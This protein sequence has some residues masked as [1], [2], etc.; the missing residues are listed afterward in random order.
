MRSNIY[1]EA[2]TSIYVLALI[3]AVSVLFY[4]FASMFT[5]MGYEGYK[6]SQRTDAPL[7]NHKDKVII[8]D[9]GHGGEDPGAVCGDLKEKDLNLDVASILNEYFISS[10]YKTVMTRKEDAL[11]YKNGEENRKKYYDLKNRADIAETYDNGIFVSI[12]MNKFPV[13][14]CKGLQ[15][16]YSKNH[17]DGYAIA[18][19][20][21]SN[22]K[23]LQ[24]DNN[25][26]VKSGNDT[27]YLMNKLQMP[28][29]LIEC[30][31]LS[32]E[33]EYNLLKTDDYKYQLAFSIYCG[34]VQYLE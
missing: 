3:L 10:G 13:E 27:I 1:K 7:K 33:A 23:F 22:I 21:Q 19:S 16:F 34:V 18:E 17:N 5:S 2:R 12:H 26:S 15:V 29:V 31:F 20:V 4:F 25:R 32:N 8:I 9:A 11:L 30:G 28:S 24:D 14:Y 6:K